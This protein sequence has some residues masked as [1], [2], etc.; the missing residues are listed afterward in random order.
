MEDL[1]REIVLSQG[2]DVCGIANI[3]R[4]A[5]APGGFSP[6]D[7]FESTVSVIVLGVALPKG[8][9]KVQPRLLYGYFNEYCA[10]K[11][12]DI[13]FKAA[14]II[15]RRFN[16]TC[17]P[18]PCDSPYEYWDEES[19]TGRG[20]ISMKHTAVAAG[21]G[22]L[23]KSTLLLNRQFGNLLTVGAILTDLDLPSDE[24]SESLCIP[25][26][27]KCIDSCPAGA[28]CDGTVNQKL[29]RNHTYGTN[30]RGFGT[31][32]CNICRVVCP[33]KY[34]KELEKN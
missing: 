26:C 2:A 1:I 30:K 22:T 32:D 9:T 12:D 16:C 6:S 23:G 24:M 10:G 25:S 29:C 14:K 4:F 13:A 31:T 3:E 11:A 5:E 18:I 28:I 33:M 21:L 7:L 34:G 17:V 19:R 8:L 27:T 15:E 20:L